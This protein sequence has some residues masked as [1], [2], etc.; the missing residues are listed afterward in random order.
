MTG[1]CVARSVAIA[2]GKP[3]QEVYDRLANGNA[4]QKKTKRASKRTG[5]HTASHGINVKRKW[6]QEYMKSIGKL[7]GQNKLPRLS[8]DRTIADKLV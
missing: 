5:Q 8:N 6:F 1:D 2:S 4:T 7:G 3:Y